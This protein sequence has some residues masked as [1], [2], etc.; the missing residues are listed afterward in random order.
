MLASD[1]KGTFA[2][3]NHVLTEADNCC[4]HAV[5]LLDMVLLRCVNANEAGQILTEVHEGSFG[6]HANGHARAQKIMR[7]GYY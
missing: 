6:T 5:L 7:V 2:V 4:F 3:K 1:F